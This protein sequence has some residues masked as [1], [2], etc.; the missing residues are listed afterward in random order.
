MTCATYTLERRVGK[1]LTPARQMSRGLGKI[2][3]RIKE[4]FEGAPTAS[5]STSELCKLVYRTEPV[6]KKH[7]VA[8]LR[9]LRTP[10]RRQNAE[11][12]FLVL[13][14]EKTD[15]EWLG[16]RYPFRPKAARRLR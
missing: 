5:F 15:T 1:H 2:G 16:K 14:H 9:A 7:R 3:A 4:I 6:L 8:V 10:A 12:W 13:H 11:I